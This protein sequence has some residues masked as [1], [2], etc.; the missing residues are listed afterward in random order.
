MLPADSEQV[1]VSESAGSTSPDVT[2]PCWYRAPSV[3]KSVPQ[4]FWDTCVWGGGGVCVG[5]D[6]GGVVEGRNV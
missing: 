5:G 3:A 2:E 4:N 1:L 6:A